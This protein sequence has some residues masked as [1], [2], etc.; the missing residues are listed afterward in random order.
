MNWRGVAILAVIVCA[1]ASAQKSPYADYQRMAAENA[2]L[3]LYEAAGEEAWKKKQGPRNA[4]L[5]RTRVLS[6]RPGFG[7]QE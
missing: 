7:R 4:S 6:A 2:P 5:E 3:E 1:P